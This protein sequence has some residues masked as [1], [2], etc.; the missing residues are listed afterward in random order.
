MLP[1][2]AAARSLALAAIGVCASLAAHG[3][4]VTA[5]NPYFRAGMAGGPVPQ[6]GP[7]AA[8]PARG[9]VGPAPA[10][11]QQEVALAPPPSVP[12]TPS[13]RDVAAIAVAFPTRSTE[14]S[15]VFKAKLDQLAE[16]ITDRTPRHVELRTIA[17]DGDPD[18]RKISLAR[19]LIVQRY[20]IDKG[21]RSRIEI[22]S[23]AGDGAERVEILV[24]GT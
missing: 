23:T 1:S 12:P 20:L 10:P 6:Q 16:Q 19:A 11:Q 22:A 9:T 17:V 18:S 24:P 13:A 2:S 14:L 5:F 8:S 21:V 4:N 15:N 3:Q 7:Q